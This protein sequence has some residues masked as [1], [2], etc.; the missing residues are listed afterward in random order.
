[1]YTIKAI[2]YSYQNGSLVAT[3]DTVYST[4]TQGTRPVVTAHAT[5]DLNEGGNAE[6]T[7]PYGH[8]LYDVLTPMNT[9]ISITDDSNEEVFYGRILSK[10][11]PTFVGTISYQCEGA[12]S[13]LNDS[14]V[15]PD[16]RD[17]KGT[18]GKRTMTAAEFFTWCIGQHNAFINNDPRRQFTVGTIS[19]T[20]ASES[21]E[22]QVSSYTA[23]KSA[24]E[25]NILGPYGGYIRVRKSGNVRYI[26]WIQEYD[27]LNCQS[28]TLAQNIQELTNV[29]NGDGFF[30]VL[31]PVGANG[32]LLDNPEMNMLD[33]AG[34]ARYGR[35][36]KSVTFNSADTKAKLQTMATDYKNRLDASILTETSIRMVDM[37]YLDG[38]IPKIRLGYRFNN[39][40]GTGGTELTVA[41]MDVDILHPE[42]DAFGFKNRHELDGGNLAQ[43][44]SGPTGKTSSR[45]GISGGVGFSYKYYTEADNRATIHTDNIEILSKN[46]TETGDNIM[47]LSRTVGG[48]LDELERDKAVQMYGT[49]LVQNS[50]T[51]SMAAGDMQVLTDY[52]NDWPAWAPNTEYK[53]GQRVKAWSNEAGA[54]YGY[55]CSRADSG[56]TTHT[57]GTAWDSREIEFWTRQEG[58]RSIRLLDGAAFEIDDINGVRTSVGVRVQDLQD[59]IDNVNG[60]A[61]EIQGS[62]LWTQRDNITGV[63]GLFTV[64]NDGGVE[65]LVVLAGGGLKIQQNQQEF[66]YYHQD[67]LT[68]GIIVRKVNTS[69]ESPWVANHAYAVGDKI[70]YSDG[71]RICTVAHTSGEAIDLSKWRTANETR[72]TGDIITIGDDDT[73]ATKKTLIQFKGDVDAE[74]ARIRAD[75]LQAT[76]A[77]INQLF[78]KMASTDSILISGTSI[79]SNGI[80]T[81][82]VYSGNYYYTT[83]EQGYSV[84]TPMLKKAAVDTATNELKIWKFGDSEQN[85]SITFRK[86]TTLNGAWSGDIYTV[87]ADYMTGPGKSIGFS[88]TT[89]DNHIRLIVVQDTDNTPTSSDVNEKY[90]DVPIKVVQSNPNAQSTDRFITTLEN[91]NATAAWD[92]GETSGKNSV[93]INKGTWSGGMI[94]FAK[95]AGTPSTKSV[96][97]S[98]T[99]ASW[100]SGTATVNIYDG[101]DPEHGLDTG[102]SVTV[103]LPGISGLDTAAPAGQSY[104]ASSGTTYTNNSDGYQ[105]ITAG[106]SGAAAIV[107]K[108]SWTQGGKSMPGSTYGVSFLSGA[109]TRLYRKG[110]SDGAGSIT[111]SMSGNWFINASGNAERSMVTSS[112][113][114]TKSLQFAMSESVN[115]STKTVSHSLAQYWGGTW[116][117]TG[118]SKGDT[119]NAQSIYDAGVSS[120]KLENNKDAGEYN[121]G[122][123]HTVNPSSGNVA[124]K[125]VTFSIPTPN[126][127]DIRFGKTILGVV[128]SYKASHSIT[129]NNATQRTTKASLAS[130]FGIAESELHQCFSSFTLKTSGYYGFR[131]NCNSEA[132]R[133]YYFYI[134]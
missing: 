106:A 110:F 31:R 18:I 95:S 27:S 23:T 114:D 97:L 85:P 29:L 87:T 134:S 96:Q 105:I 44:T 67:N 35:I 38:T 59:D 41:H 125:K 57:S 20:K 121:T 78:A 5:F 71:T 22:Y 73:D 100:A 81:N 88:G 10:S 69:T 6:F 77:D 68:A 90:L 34:M 117:A 128:G 46:L 64:R 75:Y 32:I 108:T 37:H 111:I 126:A 60:R 131:I 2:L 130:A 76:V 92:K 84:Y 83:N 101:V 40:H 28:I 62:A 94:E 79:A 24:I 13:F 4:A 120:V 91:V 14:D 115:V 50:N 7:L 98:K 30:T 49:T 9:Y 124:M 54:Y 93:V 42:N 104:T 74:F 8:P 21:R 43:T 56:K 63:S 133:Y 33:A 102:Y 3:E 36:I 1:M 119:G 129:L 107:T 47:L 70:K 53:V 109:P 61:N 17:S 52:Y 127:S 82:S 48:T 66:G 55:V 65:R 99:A 15:T 12:I 123:P 103:A 51:L 26:D 118:Y 45:G 39:I 112:G 89:G 80:H 11:N 113:S 25:Q 19:A 16:A 116:L 58:R 72:I 122:G 86:A 132:D